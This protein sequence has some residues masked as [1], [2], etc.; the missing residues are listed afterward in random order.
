M[1][2]LTLNQLHMLHR[3]RQTQPFLKRGFNSTLLSLEKKGLVVF[4]SHQGREDA[5]AIT[6]AGRDALTEKGL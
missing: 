1:R 4:Y 2:A 5:W 6:D 3:V